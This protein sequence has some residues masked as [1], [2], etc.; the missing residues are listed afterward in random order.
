MASE[1]KTLKMSSAVNVTSFNKVVPELF[2][3]MFQSGEKS[4]PTTSD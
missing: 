2:L 4:S 1:A 3:T